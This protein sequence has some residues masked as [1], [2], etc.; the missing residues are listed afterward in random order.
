[1]TAIPVPSAASWAG[2]STTGPAAISIT[3]WNRTTG[4]SKAATGRCAASSVPA[5]RPSSVEVTTNSVTSSVPAPVTTNTFPPTATDCSSSVGA[6]PCSAFCTP[7][8]HATA[9]P[10]CRLYLLARAL[11]EPQPLF[12]G[13]KCDIWLPWQIPVVH[14]S[15]EGQL[16]PVLA[17]RG[18]V[19]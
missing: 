11:T 18:R 13:G 19:A 6:Q 14:V 2:V 17:G 1:M 15:G 12:D 7:R 8:D 3:D 9:T 5:R 10:Q 4:A 16:R